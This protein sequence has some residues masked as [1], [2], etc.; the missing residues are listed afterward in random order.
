MFGCDSIGPVSS[1]IPILS[2]Q[3]RAT[4][5]QCFPGGQMVA[6]LAGGLLTL[7]LL[8][9]VIIPVKLPLPWIS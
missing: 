1:L 8:L 5:A 4:V 2:N 7:G 9:N 3:D 6:R